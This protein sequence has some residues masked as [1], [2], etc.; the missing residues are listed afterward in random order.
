[1]ITETR[2]KEKVTKED[3]TVFIA[4][5][6]TEFTSEMEC[7]QYEQGAE[8]AYKTLLKDVLIPLWGS[9][10]YQA[11]PDQKNPYKNI[12]DDIFDDGRRECKY[13][14]FKPRKDEDIK[15]FIA[16][17]NVQN[18][19]VRATGWYENIDNPFTQLDKLKNGYD[20]IIINYEDSNFYH[21]IEA[22]QFS[23]AIK[24]IIE[25]AIEYA[26]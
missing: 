20:Y 5:D 23:E 13:Y 11:K 25:T 22:E 8:C 21:I 14:I 19:S 10:D 7:T 9:F 18:A 6:G 26:N 16:L 1:M 2:T 15:N 3:Y 12:I 17:L 4:Q 24:K